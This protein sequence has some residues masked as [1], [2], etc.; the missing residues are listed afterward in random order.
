MKDRFNKV[1]RPGDVIS[2]SSYDH[3]T[4]LRVMA[5]GRGFIL[6][7]KCYRGRKVFFIR[8]PNLSSRSSLICDFTIVNR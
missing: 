2:M 4:T 3:G 7:K 8:F 1:L 5:I 6:V